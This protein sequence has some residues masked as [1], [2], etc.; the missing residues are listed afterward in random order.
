MQMATGAGVFCI[1]ASSGFGQAVAPKLAK[2]PKVHVV[3]LGAIRKVS[4]LP[5]DTTPD[6][7]SEETTTIKVRPLVVDERQREWTTG[8]I[9][10]ITDRSFA[11][12]RIMHVNDALPADKEA[13]WVW[14]PGPWLIVDRITGHITVI[15]LP[16]YDAAI[17]NVVWFRD[18]AAYCGIGMSAKGGLLAM[19]AQVGTRKADCAEADWRLAAAKSLRSGLCACG[20]AE[21]AP[22]RHHQG[23]WRSQSDVRC[24]GRN[25]TR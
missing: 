16:D 24:S 11:V 13:R 19:V 23:D 21:D 6:E 18:Y 5:S 2:P 12:R 14:E 7:K 4:F 10:E 22:A 25:V 20:V 9:H 17:S 1:L 15:H 8:E 3:S